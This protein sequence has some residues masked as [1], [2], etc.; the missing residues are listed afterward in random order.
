M[1]N[2]HIREAEHPSIS[3]NIPIELDSTMPNEKITV[4]SDGKEVGRIVNVGQPQE[5]V[6]RVGN[7]LND[8]SGDDWEWNKSYK[9]AMAKSA[10][11]AMGEPR[12]R[13][14]ASVQK[15]NVGSNPTSPATDTLNHF[16]FCGEYPYPIR[17]MLVDQKCTG[18]TLECKCNVFLLRHQCWVDDAHTRLETFPELDADL[19]RRWNTRAPI[20]QGEITDHE[21]I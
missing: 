14:S 11:T 6:E 16:P 12:G 19:M 13:L 15:E 4:R 5:V 9:D 8:A 18:R 7:A 17:D 21:A 20:T 1:G 3:P 10:I 2:A